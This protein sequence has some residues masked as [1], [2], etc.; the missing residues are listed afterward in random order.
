[1]IVLDGSLAPVE[2]GAR[3]ES[4]AS[5]ASLCSADLWACTA[6]RWGGGAAQGGAVQVAVPGP[7]LGRRARLLVLAGGYD[8][9]TLRT[10]I[11]S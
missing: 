5:A 3:G 7:G 4:A 8:D 10:L 2:S 1:M 6:V 11:Y 9:H